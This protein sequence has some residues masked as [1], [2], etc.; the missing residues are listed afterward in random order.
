MQGIQVQ[1]EGLQGRIYES[2]YDGDPAVT[3]H[4]LTTQVSW[5]DVKDFSMGYDDF[6]ENHYVIFFRRQ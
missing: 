6:E 2:D 3:T 4:T 5:S 1:L